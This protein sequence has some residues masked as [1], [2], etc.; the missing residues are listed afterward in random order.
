MHFA[1]F[2]LLSYA[3]I[4]GSCGPA[5]G[6]SRC[7]YWCKTPENQYYCCEDNNQPIRPVQEKFGTCPPVRLEC[8]Q[9]RIATGPPLTCSN[10]GSC[11]VSDKCCFDVCLKEHV[12]KL[13]L[14]YALPIFFE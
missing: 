5:P 1:S 8:P 13:P 2:V 3:I 11:P 4:L 14:E 10:D 6:S 12:C 7:R 9:T